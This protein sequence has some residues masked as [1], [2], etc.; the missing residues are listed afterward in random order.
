M[1]ELTTTERLQPSLLDRLTDTVP[2]QREESREQRV[3]SATRLRECVIRDLAWLLNAVNL[4]TS[5]PLGAYPQVQ[6]SVLNFGIPD[7]AGVAVTGIDAA[8]LQQRIREAILAFEPRLIADTLRVSVH[9]DATRMDR[10]SLLF[11]IES[12]MW[13]Q[14]L[15]LNL[16]LKTALD[17]ETGRLD[18]VEGHG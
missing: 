12:E 5:H 9:A 17:L 1:A 6:R 4:E 10:R 3:I 14:P 13:A 18:V 16:Y 11:T 15:P 8:A 2:G 7:L